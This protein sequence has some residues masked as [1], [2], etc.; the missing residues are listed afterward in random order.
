M[1]N[2]PF[3]DL[4]A[5][6]EMDNK[7]IY[8]VSDVSKT[9]SFIPQ[10]IRHN[11]QIG[12]RTEQQAKSAGNYNIYRKDS[13]LGGFS[14]NYP[15]KES[16]LEF[17]SEG[18]IAKQLKANEIKNARGFS[19]R[20]LIETQLLKSDVGFSFT[21]LLLCLIILAICAELILLQTTKKQKGQK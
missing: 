16:I 13:L 3:I 20:E 12:I 8:Q 6:I 17:L 18:E 9:I 19:S 11:K 14:L 10:I 21:P 2:N 1:G 5:Y 7:E 4:S 15:R